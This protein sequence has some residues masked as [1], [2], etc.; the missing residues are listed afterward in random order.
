[1]L[2]AVCP[3]MHHLLMHHL[4]I[5][6]MCISAMCIGGGREAG[7]PAEG[8]RLWELSGGQQ[9]EAGRAWQLQGCWH[10]GCGHQAGRALCPMQMAMMVAGGGLWQFGLC[11]MCVLGCCTDVLGCGVLVLIHV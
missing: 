7:S 9:W 11:T 8:A 4:L 3:H 1:M 5:I 2:T 6:L 10:A